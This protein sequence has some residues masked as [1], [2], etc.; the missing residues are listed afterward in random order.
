MTGFGLHVHKYQR[1]IE[2]SDHSQVGSTGG[3]SLAPA[4][5]RVH[6]KYS[7]KDEQVGHKNKQKRGN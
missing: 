7:Y 6:P 2:D 3:E 5:S 1:S 4:L